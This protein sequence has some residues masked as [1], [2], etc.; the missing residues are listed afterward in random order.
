MDSIGADHLRVSQGAIIGE[1]RVVVEIV[2][3]G[4][5]DAADQAVGPRPIAGGLG[6][7]LGWHLWLGR[8]RHGG[9][10]PRQA[11][12]DRLHL[13]RLQ[14]GVGQQ[15]QG[16]LG[17]ALGRELERPLDVGNDNTYTFTVK[18]TNSAGAS[19]L[20]K[21][22]VHVTDVSPGLP[23]YF[24]DTTSNTDRMLFT[25]PAKA[26]ETD[27]VQFFRTER[28]DAQTLPLKAWFN[29]LTGDWFYGVEGV[30][31]PYDCYV[32]RPEIGRAHV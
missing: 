32:E 2:E 11:H 7:R 28:T 8:G 17:H 9:R 19:T 26:D 31:P 20:Q 16:Q 22:T 18:A 25:A 27:Q 13:G 30:A 23:V 10:I 4:L 3:V 5:A 12:L 21:V 14:A 29:P 1:I 15:A 6:L 24:S